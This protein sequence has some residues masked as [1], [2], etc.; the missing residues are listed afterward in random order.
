MTNIMTSY[1]IGNGGI[2]VRPISSVC[3]EREKSRVRE[4]EKEGEG[5]VRGRGKGK[6]ERKG[7]K[8]GEPIPFNGLTDTHKADML[9]G[10]KVVT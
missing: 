10:T 6:G 7:G 8:E 3:K 4:G 9:L 5:R 2:M 1:K